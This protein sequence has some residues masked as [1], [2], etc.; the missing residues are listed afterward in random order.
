MP[1]PDRSAS[2]RWPP[3]RGVKDAQSAAEPSVADVAATQGK[4]RDELT[5]AQLDAVAGGFPFVAKPKG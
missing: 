2:G 4:T 5:A 1:K 3:A